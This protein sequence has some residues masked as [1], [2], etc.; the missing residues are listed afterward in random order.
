MPIAC[1]KQNEF[2]NLWNKK[3]NLLLDGNVSNIKTR[4]NMNEYSVNYKMQ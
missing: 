1:T 4:L 3:I 2:H